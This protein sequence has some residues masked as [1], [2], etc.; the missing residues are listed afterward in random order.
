MAGD[1]ILATNRQ[2][3]HHY[4]ILETYECGIA[5]KGSEVKS[6][7][8]GR[9]NLKD[10]YA[11]VRNG[12]AWLVNT[13]ISP[14]KY[15]HLGAPDPRRDRKL[16]LHKSQIQRLAGKVQEKGLTLVP[17]KCYLKNGIVKIEVALAK[18]KKLYDKREAAI[19]KTVEREV[20]VMLKERGK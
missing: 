15:S 4:E 19:R 12:E 13:H 11:V 9:I 1:R 16:L 5:L 7:R 20:E 8:E 17:T 14:Y 3:Y 2:A 6:I 18:G 10:G